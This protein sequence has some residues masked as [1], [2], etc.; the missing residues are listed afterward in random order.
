MS[1]SGDEQKIAIGSIHEE[2]E[3]GEKLKGN[4]NGEGFSFGNMGDGGDQFDDGFDD[5]A[6]QD[7][8][9][10]YQPMVED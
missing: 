9:P 7:Q 10:I 8:P 3:I 4:D 1:K 5:G 2:E 6:E